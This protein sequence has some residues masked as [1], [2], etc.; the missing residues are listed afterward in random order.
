MRLFFLTD[1]NKK[2]VRQERTTPHHTHEPEP[3]ATREVSSVKA[4]I[5]Q[6]CNSQELIGTTI[7]PTAIINNDNVSND[8]STQ[9]PCFVK[10]PEG[11]DAFENRSNAMTR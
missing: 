8:V 1:A 4:S 9:P 11:P 10:Y 3:G 6:I 5:K 2:G 7:S